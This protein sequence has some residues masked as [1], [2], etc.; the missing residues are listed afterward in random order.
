MPTLNSWRSWTYFDPLAGE[1]ATC[2][3][4][5]TGQGAYWV[6]VLLCPPGK[7]RR[8]QRDE[9]LGRIEAAIAA[10]DLPGEV[11]TTGPK[12]VPK[13]LEGEHGPREDRGLWG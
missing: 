6:K 10:G 7:S 9:M 5:Y 13:E 4:G 8:A 11:S 3:I 2:I 12:P 1:D